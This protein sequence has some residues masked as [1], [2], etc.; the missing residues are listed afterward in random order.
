M[1]KDIINL[2]QNQVRKSLKELEEQNVGK[3]ICETG[4]GT[5]IYRIDDVEYIVE[6]RKNEIQN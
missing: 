2:L 1:M 4:I 5:M 3:I 6:V